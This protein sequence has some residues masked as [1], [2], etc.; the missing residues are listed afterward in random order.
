MSIANV[1]GVDRALRIAIGAALFAVSCFSNAI[2]LWGLVG[3]I[4]LLSGFMRFCPLYALV[5]FS[6]CK[7]VAA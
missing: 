3:V 2:G 1:G 4:P 6:T 5:G 7:Q